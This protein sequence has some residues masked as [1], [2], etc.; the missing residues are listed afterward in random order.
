MK[1]NLYFID[2]FFG[3]YRFLSNFYPVEFEWNGVTWKSSEHAYQAM[4]TLDQNE[5]LKIMEAP[6]PRDAKSLGRKLTIRDDW[7]EVKYGIMKSIVFAKFKN[8]EMRQKLLDTENAILIEG[9]TWG[10]CYWGCTNG[11]GLNNL[12]E[13]L[14]NTREFIKQTS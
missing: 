6:L 13:I 9:N 1:D 14:M 8:P 2:S 11:K 12:G 3:E 4:K 10:D 5:R 7:E